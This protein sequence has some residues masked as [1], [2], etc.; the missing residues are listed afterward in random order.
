LH[1]GAAVSVRPYYKAGVAVAA[2]ADFIKKADSPA[3]ANASSAAA[4]KHRKPVPW[5][6][7]G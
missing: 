2:M 7:G 1:Y 5:Q 3:A 6:G 4:V